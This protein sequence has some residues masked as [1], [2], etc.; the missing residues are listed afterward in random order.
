MKEITAFL[1]SD[2][3]VFTDRAACKRHE[4][5][6]DFTEWY[7]QNE[8]LGNLAGSRVTCENMKEWLQTNK[9]EVMEFLQ[10]VGN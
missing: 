8:L 7:T 3:V 4:V 5:V 1:S 10:A 6:N 2:G 9:K